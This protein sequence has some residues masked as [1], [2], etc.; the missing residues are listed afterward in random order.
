MMLLL[1]LLFVG[2]ASLPAGIPWTACLYQLHDFYHSHDFCQTMRSRI[3]RIREKFR[4][5]LRRH[6]HHC[7]F[8]DEAPRLLFCIAGGEEHGL[9]LHRIIVFEFFSSADVLSAVRDSCDTVTSGRDARTTFVCHQLFT[10]SPF[11]YFF[12]KS[13]SFAGVNPVST[14]SSL[15][16]PFIPP[17]S[18]SVIFTSVSFGT[19]LMP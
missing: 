18:A 9:Q 13:F 2:R 16:A 11:K 8:F 10:R 19:V 12:M 6:S 17:F 1:K 15:P 3:K 4:D 14:T 7:E 5:L